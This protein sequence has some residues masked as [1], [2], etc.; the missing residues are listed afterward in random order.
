[1]WIALA[2]TI[3]IDLISELSRGQELRPSFY[4][5][6]QYVVLELGEMYAHL[7]NPQASKGSLQAVLPP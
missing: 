5:L 4:F 6:Y 2:L 3:E 7:V 1:M